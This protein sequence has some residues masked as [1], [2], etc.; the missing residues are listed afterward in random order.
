MR[1]N[2]IIEILEWLIPENRTLKNSRAY[3][4]WLTG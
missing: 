4:M 3:L 2:P 1:D